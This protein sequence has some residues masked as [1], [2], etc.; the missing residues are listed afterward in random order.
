MLGAEGAR[1]RLRVVLV[2]QG[3]WDMPLESLPLASGYLKAMVLG[4]AEAARPG[5][6]GHLQLP[7]QGHAR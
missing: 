4:D 5:V 1:P 6:G 3:V 7:R 2:Q